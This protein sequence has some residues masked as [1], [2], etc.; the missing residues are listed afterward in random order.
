MQ[1]CRGRSPRRNKLWGSPF[2]GGEGGWGD[3]GKKVNQRQGWQAIKKASRPPGTCL[4][5]SVRA[6]GG[7]VQ[8]CRGLRP[9]EINFGAPPSPEGKSAL[10]A[11]VGGMGAR[12]QSKGWGGRR[13]GK[14]TPRRVPLTPADP[15]RQGQSPRRHH[16]GRAIRRP[17][18]APPIPP[19]SAPRQPSPQGRR[20]APPPEASAGKTQAPARQPFRQQRRGKIR[21]STG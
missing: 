9:G 6:A 4:A 7:S 2:P 17:E 21:S 11:R 10:R 1:G 18:P 5:R 12:R 20:Q 3:G 16:S 15:A 13:Q 8:G 14:Q 19:P